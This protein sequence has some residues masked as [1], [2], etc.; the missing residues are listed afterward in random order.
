ME[1]LKKLSVKQ[2]YQRL[3]KAIDI[4]M[5]TILGPVGVKFDLSVIIQ[6]IGKLC[7]P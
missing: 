7:L 1:Y 4:M 2:T 5:D 3:L 6:T